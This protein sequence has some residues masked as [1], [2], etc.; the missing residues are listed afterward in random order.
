[1]GQIEVVGS[2]EGQPGVGGS[3]LFSEQIWTFDR[4]SL[5]QAVNVDS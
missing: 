3:V 5:D 4:K 1:M 2:A